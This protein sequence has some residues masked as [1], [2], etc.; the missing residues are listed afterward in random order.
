LSNV[1]LLT[2]VA[3]A[4]TVIVATYL[5]QRLK[6]PAFLRKWLRVFV[7]DE[8]AMSAV[9]FAMLGLPLFALIFAALQTAVVLMAEQELQTATEEAARLVMTGQV[10]STT[11]QSTTMTQAQ[12]T[13]KVCS[14][15][16][17][18]FN[19][20]NLMVNAQTAT[21]FSNASTSAP[22]YTTLQ[23]NQWTFQT[24]NAGSVVV[25]QV[26]YEWP[27]IGGIMGYSLSNLPNGKRL[28]MATAV[29][30]NEPD[31]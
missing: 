7:R 27:V 1:P 15:L 2:S 21:S 11:G 28:L 29:F 24:G 26:M 4:G 20:A 31:L 22:S 30:Q 19:C 14:Y 9:E 8:K 16:V 25:V 18:L 17:S 3:E 5:N 13:S 6:L 23:T 10:T 12:F